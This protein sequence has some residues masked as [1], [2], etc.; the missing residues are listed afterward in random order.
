M[1]EA[2]AYVINNKVEARQ[3]SEAEYYAAHEAAMASGDPHVMA[4]LTAHPLMDLAL[5]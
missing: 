4:G 2:E 5:E 3:L 1:D